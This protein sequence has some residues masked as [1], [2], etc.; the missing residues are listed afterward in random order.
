MKT[1]NIVPGLLLV[2]LLLAF[3]ATVLYAQGPGPV[4]APQAAVG[5]AFTYQ[6][7]LRRDSVT[8]S[9]TCQMEFRLYDDAAAGS[10]TNH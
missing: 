8:V 1:L 10:Q 6:G 9:A 5:T 7:E 3:S 4:T 2:T